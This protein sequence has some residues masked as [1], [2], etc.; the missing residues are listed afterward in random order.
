MWGILELINTLL[1]YIS[2]NVELKYSLM[3]MIGYLE[4][5]PID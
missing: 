2:S 3:G 1:G 4:F 5:D